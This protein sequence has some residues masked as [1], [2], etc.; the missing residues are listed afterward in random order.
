MHSNWPA[1]VQGKTTAALDDGWTPLLAAINSL[2]EAGRL[3][4]YEQ[5]TV[6]E[7]AEFTVSMGKAPSPGERPKL[8]QSASGEVM[9]LDQY[10]VTLHAMDRSMTFL[11][12]E[13][14]RTNRPGFQRIT[15]NDLRE[16]QSH[17]IQQDDD[18]V[19]HLIEF[20]GSTRFSF[21]IDGHGKLLETFN[22]QVVAERRTA[23][24][25]RQGDSLLLHGTPLRLR[26][27]AKEPVHGDESTGLRNAKMTMPGDEW[28]PLL[29]AIN[30]LHLEGKLR[31]DEEA[32][33]HRVSADFRVMV[34]TVK[35][36]E[37]AQI[38]QS[39]SGEAV[40]LDEH[41]ATVYCLNR[42]TMTMHL[43]GRIESTYPGY[44]RIEL[45]DAT[46]VKSHETYQ[47]FQTVSHSIEFIGG[48]KFSFLIDDNGQVLETFNFKVE[49][50]RLGEGTSQD[51]LIL[52][53]TIPK[54]RE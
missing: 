27:A 42:S 1:T 30:A 14:V 44:K 41:C 48:S 16:V 24:Q 34:G 38:L 47:L 28:A 52:F 53:G 17:A 46:Q 45:N 49:T 8:F 37:R 35:P 26:R 12:P 3:G 7:V 39:P 43:D 4:P 50:E 22:C 32:V 10:G 11:R 20:L 54:L 19:S 2:R 5:P 36:G 29:C 33:V 25:G 15:I 6:T 13:S 23:E 51:A 9:V 21:L 31:S 18:T 40:V